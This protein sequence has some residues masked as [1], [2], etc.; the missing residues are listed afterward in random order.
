MGG[1]GTKGRALPQVGWEN[2]IAPT[3]PTEQVDVAKSPSDAI[4]DVY[5]AIT[6]GKPGEWVT[7]ADLRD[8]MPAHL[9]RAEVDAAL[10]DLDR[11]QVATVVPNYARH[12]LTPREQAAAITFADTE[13]HLILFNQ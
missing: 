4:G 2:G 7:L 13:C 5:R 11:R 12:E 3:P 9:T 10:R 6:G 1:R 8:R